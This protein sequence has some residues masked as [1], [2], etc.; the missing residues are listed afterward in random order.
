MRV[1]LPYGVARLKVDLPDS[2][3]VV[4]ARFRPAA[5]DQAALLRQALRAPVAGPPLASLVAPGSRVALAV[6]DGTRPPPR[7]LMVGAILDELEGIVPDEDVI[8]LVATGTQR[9]NTDA[10]LEAMLG[11]DVLGPLKVIGVGGAL[12]Y[13]P[14]SSDLVTSADGTTISAAGHS[15]S[16]SVPATDRRTAVVRP[17]LH[18]SPG[19]TW[20]HEPPIGSRGL[21]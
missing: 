10:E 2:T 8:V 20:P 4:E 6:C 16:V 1:G 15:A 11:R 17:C 12:N 19:S 18:D 7:E 14:H 13:S 5:R 21:S 3:V 9:T